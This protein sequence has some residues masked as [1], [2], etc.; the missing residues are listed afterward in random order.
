[1][2]YAE[3]AARWQASS[4]LANEL[5]GGGQVASKLRAGE[6]AQSWRTSFELAN[7][8]RGGEQA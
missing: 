5:R 2:N 6:R 1:M 3:V 8:P 4:E 7:E